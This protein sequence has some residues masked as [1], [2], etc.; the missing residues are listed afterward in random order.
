V[1]IPHILN[2]LLAVAPA[3]SASQATPH[4]LPFS[5]G[6]TLD[7]AARRTVVDGRDAVTMETG[8]A[9]FRGRVF[10]DGQIDAD[11][12]V[13]DRRSF[14]YIDFRMA[15]SSEHEE[16]YLRPHKSNLPD[17]V[18]YAPVWQ[19][20]SAWQLHH[21][22]GGSVA[23]PIPH[24]A[25]THVRV[26]V[27]GAHAALF[28]GDMA[29]PALLVPRLSRDTAA[30]FIGVRGF[31]PAGMDAERP[32]AAFANVTV[33]EGRGFFDFASALAAVPAPAPPPA[34]SA[35][36]TAWSVSVAMPA[37]PLAAVPAIPAGLAFSTVAADPSGLVELHRH[38]RLPGPG[39]AAV[40]ARV[41]VRA[42]EARLYA[43]DLGFS[44]MATVFLNG[45][46]IFTRD[47]SYV[48][49]GL[50]R[51]GLITLDQARVYLP[52]VA[53]D[54]RLEILLADRFGGMGLMARFL[55]AEGLTITPSS[56]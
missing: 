29:T 1:F 10:A 22:P 28:V 4:A 53:G 16:F 52:L 46:P 41:D 36:V 48:F 45:R 44:D 54:N 30:G 18:Q 51:D 50:R 42:R 27:E 14:V 5:S 39:P 43:L 25:W 49:D 40:V 34:G 3:L 17:A 56:R 26:I 2:L 9:E 19:G 35:L 23:W 13:T 12:K 8:S 24:D 6:W 11:V 37:A 15:S 20:Q 55:S 32:V 7:G 21:G 33:S 38:V 31:L 47:D